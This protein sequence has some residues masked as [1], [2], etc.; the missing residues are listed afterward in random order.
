MLGPEV[1]AKIEQ[2]LAQQ[3]FRIVPAEHA[4][5]SAQLVVATVFGIGEPAT[6]STGTAI[7][8]LGNMLW[9]VPQTRTSSVR[10]LIA[11]A[12][13]PLALQNAT[14]LA[15]VSWNWYATT[16]SEGTSSDLRLVV[17]Y[18]LVSTFERFGQNPGQR[19]EVNLRENDGRVRALRASAPRD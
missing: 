5:D 12:A 17:D 3:G 19:I 7:L 14:D 4:L 15:S 6:I 16:F 18:M 2:L 13:E 9:S 8:P 1:A 10:W 11:A